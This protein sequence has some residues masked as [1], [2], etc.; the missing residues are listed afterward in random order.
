MFMTIKKPLFR[1]AI[2]TGV[3]SS[4]IDLSGRILDVFAGTPLIKSSMR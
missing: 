3:E 1:A 4:I 2:L